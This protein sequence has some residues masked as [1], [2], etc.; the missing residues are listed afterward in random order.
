MLMEMQ[1]MNLQE[2]DEI[3]K[4]LLTHY[5]CR[6][7]LDAVCCTT[8]AVQLSR[9]EIFSIAKHL[10]ISPGV[11]L[12]MYVQHPHPF[13]YFKDPCPFFRKGIKNRRYPKCE[14]YPVRPQTCRVWPM[15]GIYLI[16]AVDLCPLAG[17]IFED[18]EAIEREALI[19]TDMDVQTRE[20]GRRLREMP[21]FQEM[22]GDEDM[23]MLNLNPSEVYHTM[24][25]KVLKTPT[26]KKAVECMNVATSL[27]FLRRLLEVKKNEKVS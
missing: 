21:E 27:P 14:I 2:Y 17:E 26:P 11:F 24:T 19:I 9:G 8:T 1:Q 25:E 12:K 6:Q 23:D 15:N 22:M 20:L 18:L 10:R 16:S 7:C 5:S 3:R 4:E 13:I